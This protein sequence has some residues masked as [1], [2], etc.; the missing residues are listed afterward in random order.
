M[1]T[2]LSNKVLWGIIL[3]F[4]ISGLGGITGLV[5]PQVAVWFSL[6]ISALTGI[7]HTTNILA[8]KGVN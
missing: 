7:G 1:K 6:V 5:S 8:S 2:L 4:I 3:T